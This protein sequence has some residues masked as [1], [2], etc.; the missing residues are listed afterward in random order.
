MDWI[1]HAFVTKF[2]KVEP[3]VYNRY[4]DVIWEHVWLVPSFMYV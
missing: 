4:R 1:K 3:E 2:N